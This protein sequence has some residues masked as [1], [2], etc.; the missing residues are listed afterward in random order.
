MEPIVKVGAI[1]HRN[2]LIV[3]GQP[4]TKPNYIGRQVKLPSLAAFWDALEN[5]G[6]PEVRGVWNLQGGGYRFIQVVAIK[7]LHPGHAKMAGL[8]AAGWG[9]S[10]MNRMTIIVDE[11]VDVTNHAEVM[12]A[13]ATRWDPKTQT[14]VIDGCWT[15]YIDPRLSPEKRENGDVTMSRIII[16]AV[17]PFHWKEEFPK[18][19]EVAPDLAADVRAK[20]KDR[21]SFLRTKQG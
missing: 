7:Q 15:G 17:R 5:A 13:M 20:W 19:N 9:G 2:D 14:D 8:V 18:P 3:V 1:S 4:P 11:D 16:Y 12:W 21:L 6:V 10:Y